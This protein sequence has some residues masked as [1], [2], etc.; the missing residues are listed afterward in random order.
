MVQTLHLFVQIFNVECISE[1]FSHCQTYNSKFNF[2]L[3]TS[4]DEQVGEP[5]TDENPEM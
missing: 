5:G 2:G 1:L 4:N 3:R